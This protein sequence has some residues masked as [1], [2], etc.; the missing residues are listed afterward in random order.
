MLPTLDALVPPDDQR[1][2][3]ASK[4]ED[5]AA[6][7]LWRLTQSFGQAV[8]ARGRRALTDQLYASAVWRQTLGGPAP[9]RFLMFPPC[10][11]IKS[12]REGE[13]ILEGVYQFRGGT[14]RTAEPTPFFAAPP[15][16]AWA[17]DLHGFAWINHLEALGS[18][19][20]RNR[21]RMAVAHWLRNFADFHPIA[22]RAPVIARR[23]ITWLTH[24]RFLTADADVLY[25]SRLLWSLARQARHLARTA[26][27][28][29]DGLPRLS[30]FAAVVISGLCLPDGEG[31]LGSGQHGL[32]VEMGRQILPDGSHISRNPTA[33]AAAM[34]D[35][36]AVAECYRMRDLAVPVPLRR[37]LDKLAPALRFFLH[38]DGRL[39]QFNGA[40]EG[41]DGWANLLLSYDDAKGK[42]FA[43]APHGAFFRLGAT[44]TL[45]LADAGAPPPADVSQSAHAGCLSFELSHGTQRIIVNC[46]A[47]PMR[48]PEW[49]IAMRATAAHST[50][51]VADCS[52]ALLSKRG[53]AAKTIGARLYPGPR[54][55]ESRRYEAA[56]G[57]GVTMAHDGYLRSH[58]VKHERRIFLSKDGLD[59][60][61]DDVLSAPSRPKS[62]HPVPFAV[63]FHLHPDVRAQLSSDQHSVHLKLA[64]GQLWLMRLSGGVIALEESVY[65]ANGAVARR[66]EQ[67][68]VNSQIAGGPVLVKWRLTPAG[69][70]A[71]EEA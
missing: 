46:G 45:I 6:L 19:D 8:A 43:H 1:K 30:A 69:E 55:V 14:V 56:E 2:H 34:A 40:T 59:I 71:A 17:E 11:W 54:I 51:T 22:W 25:K 38:G 44:D 68:V 32:N 13:H 35:L 62:A 65:L 33:V 5:T 63:R 37:A 24:G 28:S 26:A 53:F 52:S 47:A 29:P 31:R 58:G 48:D 15:S 20:A 50:T 57:Q 70:N 61:G 41:P 36:I 10:L 60:R 23:I 16:E 42:P 12:P 21:A 64:N 67:I 66:T 49:A 9:D 7:T 18:D 4:Q 39:A 3:P 27:S